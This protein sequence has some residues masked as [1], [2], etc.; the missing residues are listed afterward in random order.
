MIRARGSK[1]AARYPAIGLAL[2][3]LLLVAATGIALDRLL[4]DRREEFVFT[5]AAQ[6]V[7]YVA[8]MRWVLRHGM[9][10]G[11]SVV[12][13][14]VAAIVRA[15]VLPASSLL[16]T[17][18]YRYVW[19]GRVQASGVNPYHYLPSDP[20]L[21]SLRDPAIYPNINRRDYAPTIYPPAAQV[22]F[23]IATRFNETLLT[24]QLA[25]VA[26]E[27]VA[28]LALMTLLKRSGQPSSRVLIYAWHPLPVWEF[29]GMG[30]VDAAA[31]A[32]LCLSLLAADRNQPGLTG[33]SI[34]AGTLVKPFPAAVAPALWR[35]WDWK[36]PTAALLTVAFLY[37]PYVG[38]G[39]KVFG[40]LAGYGDEEGYYEGSGFYLIALLRALSL[41]APSGTVYL[42]FALM[43][44]GGLAVAIAFRPRPETVRSTDPL[45]LG[46]AFLLLTSPHYAWDFAW[47][48]PLLCISPYPP[49]LFTTL[50]SFMIY[51]PRTTFLG[52]RFVVDTV[53][54]GGF[55]LLALASFAARFASA[56]GEQHEQR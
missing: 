31:I 30:H 46:A 35:R 12:V 9:R 21:S 2:L 23:L 26:F 37:A 36:M 6:A 40:F 53:I 43:I 41:P 34:A 54:Y 19:D 5:I 18:A 42:I 28:M 51:L 22:I 27:A 17:D 33:L 20:A 8:A 49:L 52:S 29:A 13:L 11:T 14:V 50:A 55:A 32:L 7:V 38:V 25:M 47:V 16:S 48:I 56:R 1:D 10:R 39:L 24:M 4:A 15:T 3:G 45:V 44:Y